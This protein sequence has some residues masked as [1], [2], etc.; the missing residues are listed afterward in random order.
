MLRDSLFF[1]LTD[2][3]GLLMGAFRP[4]SFNVITDMDRFKSIIIAICF[5]LVSFVLCFPFL[6]FPLSFGLNYFNQLVD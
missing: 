2:N 3:L 4:L 6:L 5:S 1:E